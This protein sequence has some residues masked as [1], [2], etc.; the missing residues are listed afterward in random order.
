MFFF[1]LIIAF[2]EN[3][4]K[5]AIAVDYLIQHWKSRNTFALVFDTVLILTKVLLFTVSQGFALGLDF[6]LGLRLLL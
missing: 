1:L 5:C 4:I 2:C 3:V 6:G